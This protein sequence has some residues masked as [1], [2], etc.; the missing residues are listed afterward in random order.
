[1]SSCMEWRHCKFIV[2]T[3]RRR[4]EN[5]RSFIV[6]H[7][8]IDPRTDPLSDHHRRRY[9]DLC[10]LP[11]FRTLPVRIRPTSELKRTQQ[12]PPTDRP[13]SLPRPV[14]SWR[15]K[16]PARP[17]LIPGDFST[18]T[19]RPFAYLP[20]PP[21]SPFLPS[22]QRSASQAANCCVAAVAVRRR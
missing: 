17:F 4:R 6:R 21:R 10:L 1:M 8:S 3:R 18:V 19:D 13:V 2:W 12:T 11:F 5:E 9:L 16:F 15:D 7:T 14:S 22:F 20:C